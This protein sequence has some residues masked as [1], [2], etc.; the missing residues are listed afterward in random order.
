MWETPKRTKC[1][2]GEEWSKQTWPFLTTT[3]CQWCGKGEK[4]KDACVHE[5]GGKGGDL[6]AERTAERLWLWWGA[7]GPLK[8][9][10]A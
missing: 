7:R 9:K 5:K 10:K 8:K 4:E 1:L 6:Q 3:V 2:F